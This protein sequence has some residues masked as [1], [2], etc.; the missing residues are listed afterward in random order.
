MINLE[1]SMN[2]KWIFQKNT[3]SKELIESYLNVIND[4]KDVDD[5]EMII[6]KLKALSGYH[7]RSE[8]GSLSTMGVRFSQMCFYMFG[9][10]NEN[11]TFI[12]SQTTI[13]LLQGTNLKSKNMLVNLFSIQYPHPY[14]NT[15]SDI[16]IYAG[17]LIVKLLCD[18]QIQCK[19]YIDEMIYFLPFIKTIDEKNYKLLINS[20]LEYRNLSYDEKLKLF[21]K[22]YNW[23]TLFA[24]CVH[25]FSYFFSRIFKSFDVL[26]I[27]GDKDHNQGKLFKFRHGD[28]NRHTT[29]RSDA[30]ES[31]K[32]YSGF[33]KLNDELKKD[34]LSLLEVYSPFDKPVSL[35]DI[36]VLSKKDWIHDLYEV[37][38]LNYLST[39]FPKYSTQR[40]IINAISEMQYMSKYSSLDGKDFENSLK[41]IM[42]L[43]RENLSVEII[44]GPGEP[45]LLCVFDDVTGRNK[46]AQYKV[47]V[48][49]KSR[50]STNNMNVTR[51][52]RHVRKYG[53]KYCIIIAPRFSRGNDLDIFQKNMVSITA[54]SLGRYCSKECLSSSDGKA[55]FMILNE[56]IENNL[57]K[58]ITEKIDDLVEQ[59]YGF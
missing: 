42:E 32:K 22:E 4:T 55:D 26:E 16:E 59:R 13:N 58:N 20:I 43:F 46:K 48:E 37:E 9:Y 52:E 50:N 25:E 57:G 31:R 10:K 51:I 14:S 18:D 24:N 34:A 7:G 54:E 11:N 44:S 36:N 23:E 19:L 12:P 56:I 30:Y 28:P 27:I 5:K 53:S 8:D 21:K 33:I 49:A 41:P 1:R 38:M 2:K 45:D 47:N 40:E 17:R 6:Q 15:S 29:F 39:I 3:N 35:D